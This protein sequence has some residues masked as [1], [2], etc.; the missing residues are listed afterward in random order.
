KDLLSGFKQ[1]A[2]ESRLFPESILKS[3]PPFYKALVRGEESAWNLREE[4][5]LQMLETLLNQKGP[6]SRAVVWAHNIQAGDYRATDLVTNG[7]KNLGGMAREKFGS[8]NV[9][10]IG[11]SA[12]SGEVS[13]CG[14]W[15][16]APIE[17]PLPP[18]LPGSIEELLHSCASAKGLSSLQIIF[19]P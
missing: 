15:A 14:S 9:A 18:A 16:S 1:R 2:S 11:L 4:G 10:L 8:E 13:A 7:F 3:A 17:M 12:F 19:S 5:M 6:Q